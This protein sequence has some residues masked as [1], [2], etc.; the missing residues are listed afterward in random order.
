MPMLGG[1]LRRGLHLVTAASATV[2]LPAAL[3]VATAAPASSATINLSFSLTG[4]EQHFTVPL[5]VTS[6]QVV[7]TGGH[8]DSNTSASPGRA[9]TVT[10]TVAVNPGDYVSVWVGGNGDS[11]SGNASFNGGGRGG[12]G[13]ARGGG[14]SDVRVGSS[15]L[16]SRVL[17]AA[18]GG[19]G[20]AFDAPGGNAGADGSS[21]AAL[22]CTG[23]KKGT[24]SAGGAGGT[25]APAGALGKGGDGGSNS[26]GTYW[27]GGGGGGLYG[28]GGGG[29]SETGGCGAGGGGGSNLVPA[30]G[31]SS[32]AA[33]NA[34][35][36]VT[37]T[38]EVDETQPPTVSNVMLDRDVVVP[39]PTVVLT[40]DA[41]DSVGV[42]SAYYTIDGGPEVAMNAEDGSFDEPYESLTANVDTGSLT[43]GP[44]EFCVVATD[45]TGNDSDGTSC[46][47][48][49]V[50]AADPNAVT[51]SNVQVSE[52]TVTQGEYVDLSA[53]VAHTPGADVAGARYSIDG[54]PAEE[55]YA[56]DG[57][58]NEESEPVETSFWSGNLDDG[59]HTACVIGYD[60]VGNTSDGKDCV[61]FTVVVPDTDPPEVSDITF[62]PDTVV[63]GAPI[64]V[65][66]TL[67]D[68]SGVDAAHFSVDGND[69]VAM[70]AVDGTFDENT[71]EVTGTIDTSSISP[72]E[73]S[74]CVDGVDGEG[75][76]GYGYD[77]EWI[78]ILDPSTGALVVQDAKVLPDPLP[79]TAT[80]KFTATVMSTDGANITGGTWSLHGSSGTLT[81]V[82]GAFDESTEE[83]TADV[84]PA[85]VYDWGEYFYFR[86]SNDAGAQTGVE[87][88]YVWIYRAEADSSDPTVSDLSASPS[89]VTIGSDV[90]LSATVTDD[91]GVAAATYRLDGGSPVTMT[92]D[93]G[94]YL[95]TTEDVTSTIATSSLSEGSHTVCVTATDSSDNTSDGEDCASFL[96]ELAPD[97]TDP[98]VSDVAATPDHPT[99]GDDV[100]LTATVSDD[101]DVASATYSLDGAAP[102]P[103]DAADGSFGGAEE[104]VTATVS[105]RDLEPG[106]H[107]L[108]VTASDSADN[109]SDGEDCTTIT[110]EAENTDPEG[111]EVTDVVASPNPVAAGNIVTVTATADSSGGSALDAAT[112][113]ID[114]S[115]PTDMGA[116]DGD[117][118]EATEDISGTFDTTAMAPGDHELCVVGTN[119]NGTSNAADDT[120]IT[121]TVL[122][123]NYLPPVASAVV[124]VPNPVILG[125][126]IQVSGLAGAFGAPL[127]S[128]TYA[129][130]GGTAQPMQ[131][132]DGAFDSPEEGVI[133]QASTSGLGVRDHEVCITVHDVLGG[134]SD[135]TA[136]ETFTILAPPD[137]TDPTVADVI[138]TPDEPTVGDDVTLTATVQDDREVSGATYV[139]DS[140]N[141][142]DMDA[143][144]G[145]FGDGTEGVTATISTSA[146]AIGTHQVCVIGV[147]AAA[148]TSDG[149]DCTTFTVLAPDTTA[150]TITSLTVTP[151]PVTQGDDATVSAT[152]D[153]ARSVA[154]VGYSLDGGDWEPMGSANRGLMAALASPLA[155]T[156]TLSAVIDTSSLSVGDHEVC[157]TATDAAGNASDG[158]DCTTFAV[159]AVPPGGDDGGS[160]SGGS[161]GSDDGSSGGDDSVLPDTG[162]STPA[163]WSGP[164]GLLA[165]LLGAA[166]VAFARRRTPVRIANPSTEP[167]RLPR[168]D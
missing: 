71:E 150:P 29:A 13:A 73:Y 115:D 66:A 17:V 155:A 130:D 85:D 33:A 46:K 74:V 15:N 138:A 107:T 96:V 111:V 53:T 131:A 147:D 98:T 133:V 165:L 160:G 40:A 48:L 100:T 152:A 95:G 106:E 81:A 10:G 56:T 30:G 166:M 18:G 11:G 4:G 108:C 49:S 32:L 12:N 44:H 132:S 93:D 144:D 88:N 45:T 3:L 8:G 92:P 167:W 117:F 137:T 116:A 63:Q 80:G 110:V 54:E 72:G 24:A 76:E 14:A 50:Q 140:D 151:N 62:V 112:F 41:A 134:T 75:N 6:L 65:T 38:Y 58:F 28:G 64:V 136:C 86:V 90:T 36:S 142:V 143:A 35:P 156:R 1:R 141:P 9:A 37:I 94:E 47:T 39:G 135:G 55:M 145:A 31:S 16:T 124:V 68:R 162:A 109:A 164:A 19:G 120:C 125:T 127:A 121:F 139:L 87:D 34:T 60:A 61:T 78:K 105:T 67:A 119:A 89:P 91:G 51:V 82:D 52:S 97:T 2:A 69:D 149:E 23:G 21:S 126:D 161:G 157:V 128:A 163:S 57:D 168:R 7:A 5:G 79:A 148:N 123:A 101:R 154:S 103:M 153:D 102:E 104:D 77:C 114:G 118:D 146:L 26:Y 20:G 129:I 113:A 25:N 59:S 27:G 159:A 43:P 158:E 42:A 70:D 122:P 83:V 84:D 22:G 99:V